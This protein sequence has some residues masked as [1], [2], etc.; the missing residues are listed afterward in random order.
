LDNEKIKNEA[1]DPVSLMTIASTMVNF[2]KG[3][4]D[5]YNNV[6]NSKTSK[7]S[8]SDIDELSNDLYYGL[9]DSIQNR[10]KDLVLQFPMLCSDTISRDTA[11]LITKAFEFEYAQ[12]V[13]LAVDSVP[14][15]S[16]ANTI[17]FLKQFHK[18]VTASYLSEE[19]R[20]AVNSTYRSIRNA[21]KNSNKN[22]II[23]ESSLNKITIKDFIRLKEDST[24]SSNKTTT[25]VKIDNDKKT[26][27]TVNKTVSKDK[28]GNKHTH[29]KTSVEPYEDNN[30][31]DIIDKNS[32]KINGKDISSIN[33]MNPIIIKAQVYFLVSKD[34]NNNNFITTKYSNFSKDSTENETNVYVNTNI[35]NSHVI[36]KD[37]LFGVKGIIHLLRSEEIKKYLPAAIKSGSSSPLFK[38]IQWRSGEIRLFKDIICAVDINKEMASDNVKHNSF[39]WKKLETM[40]QDT[41]IKSISNAI[42]KSAAID[43]K[44]VKNKPIPTCTMVISKTDADNIYNE[45]GIDLLTKVKFT[46][47]IVRHFFLLNFV[48]VDEATESVYKFDSNLKRY[49]YYTFKS[50]KPKTGSKTEF[51]IKDLLSLIKR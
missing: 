24:K 40:A 36:S 7:L 51:D 42:K 12:L 34:K 2:F 44:D 43:L 19:F 20:C 27:T 30:K 29:T 4:K 18:N 49:D 15:A 1:L 8:K 3:G 11:T 25:T 10:T 33:D 9:G 35:N 50:L 6:K 26:K 31:L 41:R 38:F 14:M 5:V 22:C 37:I 45:T 13:A 16:Q 47:D 23:N 39:W 17:E 46:F 21:S 32:P 48:I 28:N